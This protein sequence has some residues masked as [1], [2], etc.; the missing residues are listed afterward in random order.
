M[1]VY[2]CLW[3][4]ET[5]LTQRMWSVDVSLPLAMD[6]MQDSLSVQLSTIIKFPFATLCAE[7]RREFVLGHN[8]LSEPLWAQKKPKRYQA[9]PK[10]N[11]DSSP[12]WPNMTRT[13]LSFQKVCPNLDRPV[14]SSSV[15]TG[16]RIQ[17]LT[18][19]SRNYGEHGMCEIHYLAAALF[20]LQNP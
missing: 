4:P 7:H 8:L 12:W 5:S 15:P 16:S 10:A 2:F 13:L 18:Q 9:G 1:N 19:G 6:I 14:S 3:S 11:R 17:T 20:R